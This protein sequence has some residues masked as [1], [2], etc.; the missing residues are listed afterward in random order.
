LR[1]AGNV[2]LVFRFGLTA[3]SA[4]FFISRRTRRRPTEIPSRNSATWSRRLRRSGEPGRLFE[5]RPARMLYERMGFQPG[6]L[7]LVD[8]QFRQRYTITKIDESRGLTSGAKAGDDAGA[9]GAKPDRGR[10]NVGREQLSADPSSAPDH[11]SNRV[12]RGVRVLIL[13]YPRARRGIFAAS[14][15]GTRAPRQSQEKLL[16]SSG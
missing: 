7:I 5:G 16:F 9:A 8:G 4:S 10:A 2:H 12:I 1:C 3:H 15:R 6:P 14:R 13:S 11:R